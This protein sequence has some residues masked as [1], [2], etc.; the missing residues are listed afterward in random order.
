MKLKFSKS[1]LIVFAAF[2]ATTAFAQSE[3]DSVLPPPQSQIVLT[4]PQ[5]EKPESSKLKMKTEFN[6]V[7]FNYDEGQDESQVVLF[8]IRPRGRVEF[9]NYFGFRFDVG[10]NLT[11]S[12]DQTRFQNP[13]L[14]F[15]NL[16][17]ASGYVKYKEHFDLRI[18]AISQDHLD[19]PM[20]IAERGFPG[21]YLSTGLKTKYFLFR[22]KAMY[23][24]PTS[25]S[26]E[27]DRS[28]EEAVPSL[29]TYGVEASVKPVKW[30]LFK[31][32]VNQ[33]T[34]RDLPSVVA[35]RSNRLG[36]SVIGTDPSESF[37]RYEF[38]GVSYVN[39]LS[40]KYTKKF[41]QRFHSIFVDKQGAP[42]DRGRTQKLGTSW[43]FK[44]PSLTVRPAFVSFYSESDSVP[45]FYSEFLFGG[46]NREGEGAALE[47]DFKRLGVKV[48][49]QYVQAR[50]IED[51]PLQND[52]NIY[53]LHLEFT[54]DIL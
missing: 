44:F 36:N 11:S 48:K 19:N 43:Y 28:E 6:S 26:F 30:L 2:A 49:A 14:N 24:I 7:G 35:F 1:S 4:P 47:V 3:R 46:A 40:L 18:G 45:A 16:R 22:P 51:D 42:S 54:D 12:R 8:S 52:V 39:L 9:T 13:N 27:N 31:T 15:L 50:E 25:S 17:Q 5:D 10:V 41:E 23:A 29:T 37:F 53:S 38:L 32:N 33:F 20:L 34:F 21:A